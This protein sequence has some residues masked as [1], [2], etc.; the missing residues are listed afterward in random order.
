MPDSQSTP[1]RLRDRIRVA[2]LALLAAVPAVLLAVFGLPASTREAFVFEY[3]APSIRTAFVAAF[4]HFDR[5]HLAFNLAGYAL[6]APTVYLLSAA[7]G[8]H[9]RF[10]VVFVALVATCPVVLSYLNLAIARDGVGFGF[11]G[12]LM[13]LYGYLP[14]ALADHM[15]SQLDVGRTRTVAPLLFFSGLTVITALTLYLAARNPVSVPVRGIVVPVGSVLV[16]TLT[17]LLV[18]LVLV[19]V[20]YVLSIRDNGTDVR[21]NL[22]AATDRP[23]HFELA[24]TGAVLFAAIPFA[25]FPLDPTAAGGVVN[26]YVHLLGYALGFIAVYLYSLL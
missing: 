18:A 3:T 21:A 15:E 4:V 20:L 16:A 9:W 10:R 26:L 22:R 1:G 11:S 6:V 17:G 24:V 25:T 8:R 19:V 23:G 5:A 13:A 2:D 12:V 14:L 7:A